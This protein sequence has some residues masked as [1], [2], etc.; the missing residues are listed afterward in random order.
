MFLTT[1]RLI[2]LSLLLRVGLFVGK[3]LAS[4]RRGEKLD[5]KD[6]SEIIINRTDRIGDA[7]L[8]RPL[9][10]LFCQYAREKGFR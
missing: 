8:S 4:T 10:E 7:V 1:L 9:I 2:V 3:I 5:L 6:L